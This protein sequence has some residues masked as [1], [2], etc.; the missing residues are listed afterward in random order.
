MGEHQGRE[1]E[2]EHQSNHVADTPLAEILLCVKLQRPD[3]KSREDEETDAG[4]PQVV[5]KWLEE[6]L[7]PRCSRR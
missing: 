2:I 5:G 6:D 7:E 4:N 1:Q 3:S